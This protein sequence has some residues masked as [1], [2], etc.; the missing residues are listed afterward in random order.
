VDLKFF[1]PKFLDKFLVRLLK[2]TKF[3]VR[4]LKPKL[5][6]WL[7]K[8]LET[9]PLDFKLFEL[10]FLLDF[11]L[12]FN[13][14]FLDLRWTVKLLEPNSRTFFLLNIVVVR[15]RLRLRPVVLLYDFPMVRKRTR[16]TRLRL[17]STS[18]LWTIIVVVI[19]SQFTNC[20]RRIN[21]SLLRI[22][23]V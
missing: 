14:I 3:V 7:V 11:K 16:V 15:L 4:L 9:K 23:S 5:L 6:V 19:F 1:E 2:P 20:T 10:N 22:R 21:S 18:I 8:L 13:P 17:R 12:I